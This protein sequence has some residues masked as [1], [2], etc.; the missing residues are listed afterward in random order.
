MKK[1]VTEYLSGTVNWA[2]VFGKARLNYQ[3]D[4]REWSLNLLPDNEALKTLK[5]HKL[6]DR[7]REDDDG[8]KYVTLRSKTDVNDETSESPIRVYDAEY[9]NWPNNTL[10]GNGSEVTVKVAIVDYGP[11]KKKGIYPEAILVTNLVPYVR[12]DFPEEMRKSDKTKASVEEDF[13]D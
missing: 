4:A 13:E 8:T 12:E 3:K 5:A 10:I 2:K 11:G 7:I 9:E 6:T 1:R